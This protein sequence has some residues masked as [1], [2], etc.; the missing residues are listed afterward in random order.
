MSSTILIQQTGAVHLITDG[1][2]YTPDGILVDVSSKI[3]EIPWARSAFYIRGA[4]WPTLTIKHLAAEVETFDQFC[5]VLPSIMEGAMQGFDHVTCGVA[6]PV[7]RHFEITCIGWSQRMGK[8][9]AAIAATWAPNDPDDVTGLSQAN[10]YEQYQLM[11]APLA[12][13][14][15][16]IDATAALGRAIETPEDLEA[17]DIEKDGLALIEAQRRL[18]FKMHGRP[19]YLVGGIAELTTVTEAGVSR[20]T[21]TV[22]PD[23]I[24]EPIQPEGAVS[25][26]ELAERYPELLAA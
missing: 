25:V 9:T 11:I 4:S 15:P 26:E 24:G 10:G 20:K 22:W 1:A 19:A 16:V 17:M 23:R 7:T 5:D 14:E 8:V 6:D 18:P 3:T 2:S 13:M 21:L 12:G